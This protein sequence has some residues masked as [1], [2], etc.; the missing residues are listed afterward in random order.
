MT[1]RFPAWTVLL[2][3][4]I[5]VFRL[6]LAG[7]LLFKCQYFTNVPFLLKSSNFS[8]RDWCFSVLRLGLRAPRYD[9]TSRV[10]RF[11]VPVR[12]L[13]LWLVE[14]Y[15]SES[16]LSQILSNSQRVEPVCYYSAIRRLNQ[17]TMPTG[18]WL[19]ATRYS[20]LLPHSL[21]PMLDPWFWM[22]DAI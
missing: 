13:R 18:F 3:S 15:G 9:P 7:I 10:H 4:W 17:L 6:N 12:R 2:E 16:R 1:C 21:H 5:V 11:R 14:A 8:H 19:L 22:L 20:M